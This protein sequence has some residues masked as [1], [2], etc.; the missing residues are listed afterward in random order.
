ML[1]TQEAASF[2]PE[3][4]GFS[5]LDLEQLLDDI[6]EPVEGGELTRRD[7][8]EESMAALFEE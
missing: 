8:S 5:D 2:F 3:D 7:S 4:D 6:G 1:L